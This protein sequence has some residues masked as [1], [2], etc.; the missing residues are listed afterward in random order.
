[1]PAEERFRSLPHFFGKNVAGV[2]LDEVKGHENCASLRF[3]CSFCSKQIRIRAWVH[4]ACRE[5]N[6]PE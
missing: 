5:A 6:D 1:M 2:F 4:P 3:H